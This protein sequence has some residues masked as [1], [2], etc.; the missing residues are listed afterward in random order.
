MQKKSD[1]WRKISI[2][3]IVVHEIARFYNFTHPTRDKRRSILERLDVAINITIRQF[4]RWKSRYIPNAYLH[5]E[6]IKK[7]SSKN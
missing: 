5:K 4:I 2:P 3:L 6:Y 7:F 1:R